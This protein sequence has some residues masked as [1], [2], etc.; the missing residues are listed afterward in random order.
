MSRSGGILGLVVYFVMLAIAAIFGYTFGRRNAR[1]A[2][3]YSAPR[4]PSRPSV[5]VMDEDDDNTPLQRRECCICFKSFD[6][7]R[8]RGGEIHATPC[9]H[10]FCYCCIHQA[11]TNFEECPICR[12]K[13]SPNETIAI[14]WD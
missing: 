6:F 13:V 3:S 2:H 7:I 9:R 12:R 1:Q 14:Y 10:L 5:P 8:R 4:A 11:L